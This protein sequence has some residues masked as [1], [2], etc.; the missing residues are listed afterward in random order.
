V[1]LRPKS[2]WVPV[3]VKP[4]DVQSRLEKAGIDLMMGRSRSPTYGPG[5]FVYPLRTTGLRLRS[6][7]PVP[8]GSFVAEQGA[9][10]WDNPARNRVDFRLDWRG[11]SV[12]VN[13]W[14]NRVFGPYFFSIAAGGVSLFQMS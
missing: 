5:P 14:D 7:H 3:E 6:A 10:A 13:G 1:L 9:P 12:A 8:T 2:H 11:V 4:E